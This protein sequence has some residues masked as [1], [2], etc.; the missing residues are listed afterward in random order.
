[1]TKE[2]VDL[3]LLKKLF[4]E[5]E[6][7]LTL[8]DGIVETDKDTYFVEMSKSAGL[9]A[10]LMQEASLLIIDIYA[11][12]NANQPGGAKNDFLNNPLFGGLKG[13]GLGNAN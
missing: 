10:G 12:A 2:K 8:A 13:G 7:S 3:G 4:G 6:V 11:V 9:A 5:L 1:M